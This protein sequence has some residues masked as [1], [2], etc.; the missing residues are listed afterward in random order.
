[1]SLKKKIAKTK[2]KTP[3]KVVS[4][5]LIKGA[6]EEL[7]KNW[8]PNDIWRIIWGM[9]PHPNKAVLKRTCKY[10]YSLNANEDWKKASHQ[11]LESINFPPNSIF[12]LIKH[13]KLSVTKSRKILRA[14]DV[15]QIESLMHTQEYCPRGLLRLLY[16]SLKAQKKS[17]SDGILLKFYSKVKDQEY[18]NL[19]GSLVLNNPDY[20]SISSDALDIA[21]DVCPVSVF[22]Y[23]V[24][25][26]SK[27]ILSKF[28]LREH[29]P[30]LPNKECY[31]DYLL[32][33]DG[34]TLIEY[35]PEIKQLEFY[36]ECA[37]NS[38]EFS[39]KAQKLLIF[40]AS[41]TIEIR[42]YLSG[43]GY[44]IWNLQSPPPSNNFYTDRSQWKFYVCTKPGQE[45]SWGNLMATLF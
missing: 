19:V 21:L 5:E 22:Q 7:P 38:P 13:E 33:N 17:I 11:Y 35:L 37:R 43:L 25:V 29:L 36:P 16:K 3:V 39:P 23:A 24:V 1:M 15:K 27:D 41:P 8:P 9:L 26:K 32:K 2:R 31:F 30:E 28:L 42:N 12:S 44:I 10:F 4:K 14:R 18:A 40:T 34:K 20:L 45:D 6:M